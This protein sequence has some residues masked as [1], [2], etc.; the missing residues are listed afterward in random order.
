VCCRNCAALEQHTSCLQPQAPGSEGQR[1]AP[2][3]H[4]PVWARMGDAPTLPPCC[5]CS[6]RHSLIMLRAAL[7]VAALLVAGSASAQSLSGIGM[8][9]KCPPMFIRVGGACGEPRRSLSL[10]PST[11][12]RSAPP[13]A[14][15]KAAGGGWPLATPPHGSGP[16]VAAVLTRSGSTTTSRQYKG[17]QTL[18]VSPPRRPATAADAHGSR[19]ACMPSSAA[20]LLTQQRCTHAQALRRWRDGAP[21]T[22]PVVQPLTLGDAT[23]SPG[24]A[25]IV[26]AV[27]RCGWS[28]HHRHPPCHVRL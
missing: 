13:S 25:C 3:C 6:D 4:R 1:P 18:Q 2:G 9:R 5:P 15:R 26:G 21:A 28:R 11:R 7:L 22:T 14:R 8:P 10:L 20:P 24:G 17:N 16:A 12:H 19:D 27:R 23:Y